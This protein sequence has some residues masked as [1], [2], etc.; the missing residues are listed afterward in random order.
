MSQKREQKKRD[1]ASAAT[2]TDSGRKQRPREEDVDQMHVDSNVEG[3]EE[4]LMFEDPF[5]DEYEEEDYDDNGVDG[6]FHDEDAEEG[7]E[8]HVDEDEEEE[9]EQKQVWRPGIDQLA[10]GEELEYDPSA[11]IMY[12]SLT[13]EWPCL[14]FDFLKDDLGEGRTRV[15]DFCH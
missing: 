3:E 1:A 14:S 2:T 4:E 12:H 5:G 11:Y 8:A 10:E 15:S 13:G 7:D 6:T 9:Q